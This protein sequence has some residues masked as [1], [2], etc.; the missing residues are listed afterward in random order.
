MAEW[1]GVR[2]G[3]A[4]LV[5]RAGPEGWIGRL[6]APACSPSAD[7]YF[8]NACAGEI[9][10]GAV[11]RLAPTVF[12]TQGAEL[13]IRHDGGAPPRLAR[14]RLVW[15]MDDIWWRV[16]AERSLSP[17]YR[18]K[19]SLLEAPAARWYLRH[20][21]AVVFGSDLLAER[22]RREA[23]RAAVYRLDPYWSEPLGDL[24]H[25]AGTGFDLAFLG[26]RSHLADL[27][28]LVPMLRSFLDERPEATLTLAGEYAPPPPLAGH[29]RV[30]SLRTTRWEDYRAALPAL[31]FH[32]ALYPLRD[33]PF[34]AA[35]SVNKLIEHAI[36]GAPTATSAGWA[37]AGHAAFALPNRAEDWL[38]LLRA[39]AGDRDALKARAA[40]ALAAAGRLNDPAPQRDLWSRLLFAGEEH[41]RQDAAR[42]IGEGAERR[43][44]RPGRRERA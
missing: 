6:L 22:A 38:G 23:P 30:R 41:W 21:D 26:S 5:R 29:P 44:Q 25:F 31:R 37:Y 33:T 16:H 4:A 17:S 2:R 24:R 39:M 10:A 27:M 13:V 8:A 35:R 43:H 11:R 15:L 12:A 14:R 18:A 1:L 3:A 9:A 19:L 36:A 28:P 42:A 40:A 34:N 7:L 20:A 32:L